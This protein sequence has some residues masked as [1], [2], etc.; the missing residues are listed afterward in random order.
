MSN[1]LKGVAHVISICKLSIIA[2][3]NSIK[4]RGSSSVT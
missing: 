2:D 4:S 3:K 1:H